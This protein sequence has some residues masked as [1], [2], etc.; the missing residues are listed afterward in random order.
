MS[1]G[2]DDYLAAAVKCGGRVA[3]LLE[4]IRST[5]PSSMLPLPGSG[6]TKQRFRALARIA[7]AD[8]TAARVLEPH[9]DAVAIL[10]EAEARVPDRGTAWGVFAAEAPGA[11]LV[12]HEEDEGWVLRGRKEW[13]SLAGQLTDALV[14]AATPEGDRVMFAVSL[15]GPRVRVE[16]AQWVARGLAEVVS[17]PVDFDDSPA[18]PVGEEGWY[19][20]RPGF[21]WGAIGVAACWWGGCLPVLDALVA[22]ARRRPDDA[23]AAARTGQLYRRLRDA[24]LALEDAASRIDADDVLDAAVLAHAVRG[25]VADAV[26]AT[27]D[28]ARDVLGPA[29]LAF[30]EALARR[31]ADLELYASQY[32]RGRDDVA[33]AGHLSEGALSW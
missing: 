6:E 3:P 29:A 31:C 21:R 9:L 13:C 22:R 2:F 28:A 33:L 23:I 14:T 7:A 26:V 24:R 10:A 11:A 32:H 18:R 20:S 8:V 27:L 1:P 12:A 4:V 25:T 5:L 15:R 17:G 19:L 16:S 30:D